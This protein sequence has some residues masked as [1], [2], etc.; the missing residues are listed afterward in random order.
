VFF[1]ID[2]KKPKSEHVIEKPAVTDSTVPP[3]TLPEQLDQLEA[4]MFASA[5]RLAAD[6]K[7]REKINKL[8][9]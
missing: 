9:F 6:P 1:A 5:Q 7:H 2:R 3:R 8:L 4:Q